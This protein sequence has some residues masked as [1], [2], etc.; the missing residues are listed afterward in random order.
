MDEFHRTHWTDG[1]EFPNLLAPAP[2]VSVSIPPNIASPPT[3]G[4]DVPGREE[5]SSE[6]HLPPNGDAITADLRFQS[7]YERYA[8][9][10]FE[11]VGQSLGPFEELDEDMRDDVLLRYAIDMDF[12]DA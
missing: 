11:N 7:W 2:K 10:R 3:S 8:A 5:T 4:R 12:G 1:K 9:Q 6:A